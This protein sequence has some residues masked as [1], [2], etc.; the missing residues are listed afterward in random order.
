MSKNSFKNLV[1][2]KSN[3]AAL[4]Y[5]NT[6]K[7]SHSKLENLSY[8]TLEI[9]PYL[10]TK[11]IFP[12]MAQ[13]IFKWRTRMQNFRIN[14]KNGSD[15]LSCS[16]G[17]AH[18]DSQENILQCNVVR[19]TVDVSSINYMNIFSTDIVTMNATAQVLDKALQ[20][21]KNHLEKYTIM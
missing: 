15:N 13:K 20:V 1:R 8:E 16:L 12:Q 11:S 21:R 7:S 10:K 18:D 3:L 6:L 2:K 5:L 14:F 4:K 19:Q 9:Q 17:C